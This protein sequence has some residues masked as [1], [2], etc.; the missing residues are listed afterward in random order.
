MPIEAFMESWSVLGAIALKTFPKGQNPK[1]KQGIGRKLL[2]PFPVAAGNQKP[3]Q[4]CQGAM[5]ERERKDRKVIG[6]D[7]LKRTDHNDAL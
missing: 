2:L 6:L 5:G 1:G 4:K 7:L 3:C